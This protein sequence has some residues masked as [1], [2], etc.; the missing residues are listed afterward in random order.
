MTLNHKLKLQTSSYSLKH[1]GP[2][3]KVQGHQVRFLKSTV[4]IV[5]CRKNLHESWSTGTSSKAEGTAI[6]RP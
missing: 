3:E 2:V 6:T 5:C 1:S 4:S